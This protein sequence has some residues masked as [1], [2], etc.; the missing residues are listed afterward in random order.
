MTEDEKKYFKQFLIGEAYLAA[1]RAASANDTS[2]DT[3][4]AT[5][6]SYKK[7]LTNA[8]TQNQNGMEKSSSKRIRGTRKQTPVNDPS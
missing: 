2:L 3:I 1:E 7:D 6:F 8:K 4:L 5:I